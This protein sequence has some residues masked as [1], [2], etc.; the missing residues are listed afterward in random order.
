MVAEVQFPVIS[1]LTGESCHGGGDVAQCP[2]ITTGADI[3][4]IPPQPLDFGDAGSRIRSAV[5]VVVEP[6]C[7]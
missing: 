6:L 2:R 1:Q 7:G 3:D 4:Q 5:R